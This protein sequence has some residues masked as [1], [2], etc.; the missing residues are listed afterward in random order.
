[1]LL[2]AS[3]AALFVPPLLSTAPPAPQEEEKGTS[4]VAEDVEI[5]RR[6][7]VQAIDPARDDNVFFPLQKGFN[8][9]LNLSL[10]S[11]VAISDYLAVGQRVS[12][13]RG[14]HLPGAG[15]F[16]SFDLE[17][18][19][20]LTAG[21]SSAGERGGIENDWERMR[22]EVRSGTSGDRTLQLGFGQAQEEGRWEIDRD[23]REQAIDAVL[24]TL[25]KH[26][27]RLGELDPGDSITVALHIEGSGSIPGTLYSVLD[28]NEEDD[29]V[30]QAQNL[31]WGSVAARQAAPERVVIQVPFDALRAGEDGGG[32]EEVKRRAVVHRY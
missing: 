26:G 4:K 6:L 16:Y 28:E 12:H 11:S 15:I 20:T 7:L 32:F 14:F 24:K 10:R 13:S 30:A 22:R 9:A 17:L 23:A 21:P 1:M 5:L 31:F 25:A 8:E 3:V 19:L 2:L 18:P 27:R 29:T